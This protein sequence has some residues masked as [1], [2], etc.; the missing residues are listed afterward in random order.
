LIKREFE[1]IWTKNSL[2]TFIRK[3]NRQIFKLIEN[4]NQNKTA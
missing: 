3:I 2:K 4:N 1:E